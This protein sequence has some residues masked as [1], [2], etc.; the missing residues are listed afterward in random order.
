MD[1]KSNETRTQ[2]LE[3]ENIRLRVAIEELTVLNDIATAIS[4]TNSLEKIIE[5]M[6]RKCI[7]HLKV[8]Q[9]TVTL[10]DS[11]ED[12]GAMHTMIRRADTSRYVLPYHLDT[13]LTGWMLKNQKPLLVNDFQNDE[14]FHAMKEENHP[15]RTFLSVPLL[16][17]GRMIGTLNVFNKKTETGFTEEDKRLI[18]IIAA[19]SAQ[20]IENAR[21]LEEEQTLIH[22]REEMNVAYKIQ[23]GLLPKNSPRVDGYMI[24]GKSIPAKSVGGDYFDFI[25]PDDRHLAF[26]LGDVSG[27][28]MPAALL[29]SNLQATLRGQ[30]LQQLSPKLCL[31]HSNKIMFSNTDLDRFATLFYGVLDSENHEL[32]Y[33]NAGHNL[34][35]V[36]RPGKEP[37]QLEIGGIVLGIME[38]F[39]YPEKRFNLEPGDTVI[40]YSDGITEAFNAADEEFGEK[41]LLE[42]ANENI[43]IPADRLIDKI[44][45]AVKLHTGTRPQTDDITL[46]V[47]KRDH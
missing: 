7:K 23:T 26:C 6:V 33:A 19:Q 35:F 20:I 37:L 15:I 46:V 43:D 21:L 31:E 3:K 45:S 5:L 16:L 42:V 17:K 34:P 27:K 12:S 41:R 18:T 40:I 24:A 22:I 4:S 14:R 44:I 29:M 13:Q 30:I 47:I 10:L 9:G 2:R 8:E 39:S 32:L 25:E 38:E 36:I 11:K 28:G 1:D